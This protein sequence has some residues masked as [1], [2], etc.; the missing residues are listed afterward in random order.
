MALAARA[1]YG[2]DVSDH[3][4][5]LDAIFLEL[6]EADEGS[7]MHIG[8]ALI[9]DPLPGRGTPT[10]EDLRGLVDER[11]PAHMARFRQVLSAPHTGGLSWPTWEEG[12]GDEALREHVRHATLPA[13]GGETELLEWLGDF[14]SHRLDRRRPLWEMVLLDGLQDGCWALVNKT[15]HALVDGVGSVDVGHVLLDT[16]PE[17]PPAPPTPEPE[18][19]PAPDAA[20]HGDP[21]L[22]RMLKVPPSLLLRGARGGAD[23]AVH[24]RR[25]LDVAERSRAAV[26]VLVRDELLPAPSTSLNAPL[27]ATRRFAVVRASLADVK[28]VKDALGGTV[29]DV[30]LA[31]CTGALR[32]LLLARGE[33]PPEGFRAMV[34][35]NVRS[36]GEQLAL[37]NR[38]TS[39]FLQLPVGVADPAERYAAVV[40]SSA[41]L[42]SGSAGKGGSTI[43]DVVSLAPPVLH[44]VAARA[45]FSPRLFN[46]TITNVPGPQLPLYALGSHLRE[47]LPLVPLF[48]DHAVGIAIVSYEG[49]LAFGINADAT[50][51]GD[52]DVLVG[53]LEDALAELR[54]LATAA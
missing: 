41:A 40:A 53:G 54:A 19:A 6:E 34:P 1:A 51:M 3:V 44:A 33:Q 52:L 8:A 24:P 27:A 26:E 48:A 14:W 39:L 12:P 21:A 50:A 29:N 28:G 47:I 43:M 22:V 7:H 31:A 15:H 17:P 4:T 2:D 42:K 11:R 9:F 49:R 30:V 23:L 5:P 18:P 37:G 35:V 16:D 32:T 10:L 46:V 45:L 38:I 13:P 25:V 20:E 36:A